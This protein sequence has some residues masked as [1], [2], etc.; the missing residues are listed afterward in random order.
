V[1]GI[2]PALAVTGYGIIEGD[3]VQAT[4]LASGVHRSKPKDPRPKRLLGIYERIRALIDEYAPDDLAIE[5]HFVAEN[6]RS[7]MALGE[8][9]AAA[10]IAA[11]SRGLDV[12]EYPATTIKQ[13]VTGFGGASKE[14]VQR[15]VV[16]HLGLTAPPTPLDA[17]DALAVALTRLA[18]LRMEN[19]LAA[20][21][22]E[23]RR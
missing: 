9:R 8:A 20:A 5:Q 6:V 14:Q 2:D 15:M 16:M 3:G 19:M 22:A 23:P 10:M 1:L 4:A 11:A 13:T 7:A 21:R 17:S 18:A 12:L